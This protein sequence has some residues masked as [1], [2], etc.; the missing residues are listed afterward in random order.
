MPIKSKGGKHIRQPDYD[1]YFD[2]YYNY[3]EINLIL[4]KCYHQRLGKYCYLKDIPLELIQ[5]V[6]FEFNKLSQV[7]STH[8]PR[9][10][11]PKINSIENIFNYSQSIQCHLYFRQKQ[12][13]IGSTK[14]FYK[15]K[16]HK[17]NKFLIIK[18]GGWL[19]LTYWKQYI[20]ENDNI[21]IEQQILYWGG[22]ILDSLKTPN[23]YKLHCA[24]KTLS[25]I[26]IIASK[27]EVKLI[28]EGH[29]LMLVQLILKDENNNIDNARKKILSFNILSP[30][31]KIRELKR[32]KL[33]FKM[34]EGRT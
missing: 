15:I 10:A 4:L 30:P 6:I 23:Y 18:L 2:F 14:Q 27:E 31:I 11:L 20:Y 16:Y 9:P 17:M 7:K 13:D 29:P 26:L 5:K 21:P 19:P 25:P 24:P 22:K 34:Y 3:F 32:M 1:D 12:E 28:S 8:R 33:K